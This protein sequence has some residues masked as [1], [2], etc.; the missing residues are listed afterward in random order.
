MAGFD[1]RSFYNA[2]TDYD[3]GLYNG[4]TYPGP[5]ESD[6]T[7][8]L[9]VD[10][11]ANGVG[12]WFTLD[13]P[14][15]GVLDNATYL[16]AGDVLIDI[17]RW[18]RG[19]STSR[20]RSRRLQKFTAGTCSFTLD[21]RERL[22]DPLF[23]ASPL[24]GSI[25]PRKEVRVSYRGQRIFTGNVEDW[26][27]GY[28]VNG[29][30][31]AI[32][33]NADA[34][35]FLARRTYPAATESSELAV[36][37]FNGVLD[38]ISWPND[39]RVIVGDPSSSIGLMGD[40]H[41]DVS[42]LQYLQQVELSD[43]GAMFVN[44]A[45]AMEYH[46]GLDYPYSPTFAATFGIGGIPF[47]ALDVAYET[48]V[49]ANQVTCNYNGTAIT[50]SD[51]D[52]QTAYGMLASSY[53][54]LLLTGPAAEG[55]ATSYVD[56]FKNPSYYISKLT[57]NVLGIPSADVSAVLGL[58]LADPVQ[59]VHRPNDMGDVQTYSLVIDGIAHSA[60]PG[61]HEITF[62][63]SPPIVRVTIPV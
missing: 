53:D 50:V 26:G 60:T 11:S 61:S 62:Q 30:S 42:A 45:G 38:T 25:V 13:D 36:N 33:S 3:L 43:I 23:T 12:N 10:L 6:W 5:N 44:K 49:M 57:V 21:N 2:P 27:Y 32:P 52:S 35:S 9:A 59:V 31:I 58:E 37:R 7:V 17:T 40:T 56:T 39:A 46:I 34:F 54:T 16:L 1:P 47:S 48:D 15:K 4:F 14:V 63:M 51:G 19:L 24:F 41:D 22:F 8:E 29:D 28:D 20:G 18:V 55:F